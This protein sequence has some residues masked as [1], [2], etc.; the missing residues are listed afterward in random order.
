MNTDAEIRD[1][2]ARRNSIRAE[3]KLPPLDGR[4]FAKLIA[5]RHQRISEAVF[6]SQQHRFSRNWTSSKSWFAGMAQYSKARERVRLELKQG[7]HIEHVWQELGYRIVDDAWESDGRRTYVHD[8]DADRQFLKDLQAT[9]A[10]YGWVKDKRRLRCFRCAATGEFIEL[11]PGGAHTSGHF[12][13]H[14]KSE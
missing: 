3:A 11:E 5:A 1:Q 14:L 4:E 8:D 2:V 7:H 10:Q 12:L 13:H 9:L 6:A